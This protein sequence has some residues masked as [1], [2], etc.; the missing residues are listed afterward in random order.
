MTSKGH[1]STIAKRGIL[2]VF[3]VMA[4]AAPSLAADRQAGYEAYKRGDYATAL[5]EGRPLAEQGDAGVQ[6]GIASMYYFGQG[7][8]RD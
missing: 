6:F 4:L 5:K 8:P 3:L 7:V 2:A 1:S